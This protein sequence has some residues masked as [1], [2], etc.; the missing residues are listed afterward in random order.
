MADTEKTEGLTT[1]PPAYRPPSQMEPTELAKAFVEDGVIEKLPEHMVEKPAEVK[2]PVAAKAEEKPAAEKPKTLL[3][4]ARKGIGP[5]GGGSRGEGVRGR[6]ADTHTPVVAWRSLGP[7]QCPMG[8]ARG[9]RDRA[10][11]F[12]DRPL[13]AATA[14]LTRAM[15]D[16]WLPRSYP[17]PRIPQATASRLASPWPTP[18]SASRTSTCTLLTSPTTTSARRAHSRCCS[19]WACARV[20]G[21]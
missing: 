11:P 15:P 1:P 7:K 20:W 19:T 14:R 13:R 17:P 5:C 3:D 10:F 4:L 9:G 6:L 12:P 2:P 21:G 8:R 18:A 16:R